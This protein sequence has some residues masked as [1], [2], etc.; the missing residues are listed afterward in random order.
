MSG[1]DRLRSDEDR[2][3]PDTT[4]GLGPGVGE[5]GVR[6][7]SPHCLRALAFTVTCRMLPGALGA[8]SWDGSAPRGLA[9]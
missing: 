6:P 5:G 4:A 9:E 7:W 3:T 1:R 2:G 8:A